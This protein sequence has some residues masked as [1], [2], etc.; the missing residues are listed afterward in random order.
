[1]L[2]EE[3]SATVGRLAGHD[4]KRLDFPLNAVEK[5]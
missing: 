3:T 1:M 2:E 4:M 5:H